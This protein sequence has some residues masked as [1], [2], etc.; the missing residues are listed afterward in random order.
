M[1]P[2]TTSTKISLRAERGLGEV[3]K[4]QDRNKGGRPPRTGPQ[5]GPVIPTYADSDLDKR[6][7]NRAQRLASVPA[8]TFEAAVENVN[9]KSRNQVAK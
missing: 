7:V 5:I 8:K 3:T 9:G 2:S 6:V 1:I 4:H